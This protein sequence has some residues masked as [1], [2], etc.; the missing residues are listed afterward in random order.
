MSRRLRRGLI[1]AALV[2]LLLTLY[3]AWRALLLGAGEAANRPAVAS[4]RRVA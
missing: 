2:V 3:T 4:P 1:V